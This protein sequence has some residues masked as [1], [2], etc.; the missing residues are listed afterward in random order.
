MTYGEFITGLRLRHFNADELT[1]YANRTRGGVQNSLPPAALW[2]NIVVPLW[3]LDCLRESI[4]RPITIVSAYR[5]PRYNAQLNGA[6]SNS[7]HRLNCAIDFKVAG[8]K[9][10]TAFNRLRTMRD[11]KVFAGGLGLY[12]TFVHIDNRGRCATW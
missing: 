5:S 7:Q 1:D 4:K 10:E 8:M 9:P 12:P 11:A 2:P 6:A 3:I